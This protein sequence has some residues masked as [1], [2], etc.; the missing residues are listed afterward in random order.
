WTDGRCPLNR[1]RSA[2]ATF[3]GRYVVFYEHFPP[4]DGQHFSAIKF[5][6]PAFQWPG[7][8]HTQAGEYVLYQFP[9]LNA[10]SYSPAHV[11]MGTSADEFRTATGNQDF[12]STPQAI[13]SG[14]VDKPLVPARD[15]RLA[16]VRGGLHVS[17]SSEGS[18]LIVLPQ[19]FSHCL[20]AVDPRVRLLR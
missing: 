9:T 16:V 15:I 20:S 12:D 1:L 7:A 11:A 2:L 17:A 14:P 18:S 10:A 8:S 13:L 5:P 19:Q 6:R 4:W 3:G